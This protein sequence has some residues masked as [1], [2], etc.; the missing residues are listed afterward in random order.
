MTSMFN[1]R[2][3]AANSPMSASRTTLASSAGAYSVLNG[4]ASAPIRDT[5]SHQMIQSTPLAKNRPTRLPL[6]TPALQQPAG[7]RAPSVAPPLR[8]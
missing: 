1:T 4:T 6:P 3:G 5:A 8:S 7:E 2:L